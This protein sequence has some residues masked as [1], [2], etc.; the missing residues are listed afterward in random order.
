M[1]G[2]TA[3]RADQVGLRI[4]DREYLGWMNVRITRSLEQLAA[5]FDVEIHERW[6]T[7]DRPWQIRPFDPCEVY[8]GEDLLIAGHVDVYS[9]GFGAN[10]HAVRITGRSKT[11]DLVDCM[12]ELP[13]TEFRNA[14]LGAIARA[15]CAPFGIEVVAEAD[16]GAPFNIAAFEKTETAFSFLERL[17]RL[18]GVLLTD[19]PRGR[20][21]ITRT[22]QA[23]A[24]GQ[25]VQGENVLTG[26]CELNVSKRF[27]RYVVLSQLGSLATISPTGNTLPEQ[28]QPGGEDQPDV[29][30]VAVDPQVPRYRP[31]VSMA[32]S[33]S[34]APEASQRAR[35]QAAHAAGRSVRGQMTVVGW[36]EDDGALW[37][38]NRMVPCR[39]PFLQLDRDL[40]IAGVTFQLDAQGRR[41]ELE[42]GPPEG[43]TPEPLSQERAVRSGAD[44]WTPR[45]FS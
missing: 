23:P 12:S 26:K 22:G 8:I 7:L 25:L 24:A 39:V 33:S 27:S 20:L 35:W 14:D 21:L 19:D 30:G 32:E 37:A 13:G 6:P 36:R 9:A 40:L 34:T 4:G 38:V 18:R 28:L 42:L 10:E 16:L 11:A 2:R 43:F 41:T 1:S 15:I 17:A 29:Q 5:T 44:S 3:E 31:H 45:P